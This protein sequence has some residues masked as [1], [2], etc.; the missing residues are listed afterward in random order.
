MAAGHVGDEP[1][2]GDQSIPVSRSRAKYLLMSRVS[3]WTLL[4]RWRVD[5]TC[6]LLSYSS[7]TR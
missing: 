1:A 5:T 2:V 4:S 7:R 3:Y 6:A